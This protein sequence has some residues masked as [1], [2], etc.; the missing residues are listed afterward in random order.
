MRLKTAIITGALAIA[1]APAAT[2]LGQAPMQTPP[3]AGVTK[4]QAMIAFAESVTL[5]CLTSRAQGGQIADLPKPILD[6]FQ[7]AAAIDRKWSRAKTPDTPVWTT[8]VMGGLVTI[9]EISPDRCEVTGMQL[10]VED[11][12]H[13]VINGAQAGY[14]DFKSVPIKPG[15]NPVV[16]QLER[17]QD[18]VRYT[19]HLEGSEPGGLGNPGR[20]LMGHAFRFS[21]LTAVVVRQPEAAKPV[22]R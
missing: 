12:F 16:Y 1:V 19:I 4:T 11:S 5:A 15:Y 20:M 9:T 3:Q 8:P 22:F 2:A 21:L 7:P 6:H 18:G 13:M 10:P 14:P 17:V